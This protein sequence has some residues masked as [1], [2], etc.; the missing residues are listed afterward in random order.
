[1]KTV[2]KSV[3]TSLIFLMSAVCLVFPQTYT[4]SDYTKRILGQEKIEHWTLEPT[5]VW[6]SQDI[7]KAFPENK[8]IFVLA[9]N[10]CLNYFDDPYDRRSSWNY[11][12]WHWENGSVYLKAIGNPDRIFNVDSSRHV[13]RPADAKPPGWR[14]I[15]GVSSR[16][17]G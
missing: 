6:R 8:P 17:Q 2:K 9:D 10:E 5:A 4:D 16:D 15:P 12:S 11:N 14:S 1:M 13:G 3:Y 7:W